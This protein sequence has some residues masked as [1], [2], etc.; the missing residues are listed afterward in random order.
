LQVDL[1]T[2]LFHENS[3]QPSLSLLISKL[4]FSQKLKI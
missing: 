1:F 2:S 3:T 4:N